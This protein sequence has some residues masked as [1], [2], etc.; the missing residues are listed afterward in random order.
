M[1]LM[2]G[3]K[4]LRGRQLAPPTHGPGPSSSP[5]KFSQF[6]REV[7]DLGGGPKGRVGPLP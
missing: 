6:S 7:G 1:F 5:G 3:G 2:E 4:L